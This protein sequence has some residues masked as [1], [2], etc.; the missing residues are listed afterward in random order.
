MLD[1]HLGRRPA[2]LARE[3]GDGRAERGLD[4][5][6]LL[7][8]EP[9]GRERAEVL[10]DVR[11][12]R[13]P[14]LELVERRLAAPPGLTPSASEKKRAASSVGLTSSGSLVPVARAMP[15][16]HACTSTSSSTLSSLPDASKSNSLKIDAI[17][18][19][20]PRSSS[21]ESR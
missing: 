20:I 1:V 21:L 8:D 7:R 17:L 11:L 10:D 14:A 2:R 3:L 18:A 19:S 5:A 12:R 13:D 9:R 15:L 16:T 6:L 4:V